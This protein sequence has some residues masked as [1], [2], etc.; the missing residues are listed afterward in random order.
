M[1]NFPYFFPFFF[2]GL[3]FL[4]I[5]VISKTGWS[6]LAAQYKTLEKFEGAKITFASAGIGIASY[7]NALILKYNDEGLYLKPIFL[8]RAFHPPLFIPWKEITKVN[9]KKIF[10]TSL[11][12]LSIGNPLITTIKFKPSTFE[13]FENNYLRSTIT[14][15]RH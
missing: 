11:K 14:P 15:I 8:F 9:D 6:K 10:F 5:Y 2:F 12:E 13:K 7:N 3:W 4:T 1:Q